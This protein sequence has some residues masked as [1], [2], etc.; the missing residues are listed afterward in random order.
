MFYVPFV[1]AVIYLFKAGLPERTPV[2]NHLCSLDPFKT[3][4]NT[5]DALF[6]VQQ[7]RIWKEMRI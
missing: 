7:N 3:S 5:R 2:C 4:E 6:A 1:V